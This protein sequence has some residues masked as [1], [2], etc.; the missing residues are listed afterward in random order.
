MKLVGTWANVGQWYDIKILCL[1]F[2]K[3]IFALPCEQRAWTVGETSHERHTQP[4]RSSADGEPLV[5]HSVSQ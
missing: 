2:E 4:R 5:S 3:L 1:N